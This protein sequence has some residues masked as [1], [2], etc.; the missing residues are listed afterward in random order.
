MKIGFPH[1]SRIGL[2]EK[3]KI[4][5]MQISIKLLNFDISGCIKLPFS[6]L[7]EYEGYSSNQQIGFVYSVFA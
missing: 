6:V 1:R 3:H 2:E 4:T 7:S 5:N